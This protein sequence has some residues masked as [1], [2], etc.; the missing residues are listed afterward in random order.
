LDGGYPVEQL[1]LLDSPAPLDHHMPDTSDCIK[2]FFRDLQGTDALWMDDYLQDLNQRDEVIHWP[3]VLDHVIELNLVPAGTSREDLDEVYA[4]FVMNL[5]A[6]R[7]YQPRKIHGV[8]NVLIARA[9]EQPIDELK[10]HASA[11]DPAWGWRDWFEQHIDVCSIAGD[12]YSI[13]ATQHITG[14]G[15]QLKAWLERV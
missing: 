3:E 12:H 4:M 9:S 13:F 7:A 15:R 5:H 2:W 1:V 14:L 6:L 10:S 11:H 8:E